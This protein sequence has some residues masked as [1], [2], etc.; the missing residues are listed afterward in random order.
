MTLSGEKRVYCRRIKRKSGNTET[1]GKVIKKK[2][3]RGVGQKRKAKNLRQWADFAMAAAS[4]ILPP[5]HS[6]A[7]EAGEKN[8]GLEPPTSRVCLS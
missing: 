8:L 2:Q 3:K 6:L 5:L 7:L 1:L 4:P